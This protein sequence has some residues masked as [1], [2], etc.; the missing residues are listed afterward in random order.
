M[1]HVDSKRFSDLTAEVGLESLGIQVS[2]S[3][4]LLKSIADV[5]KKLD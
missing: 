1:A 4:N 5:L 2:P 3:G